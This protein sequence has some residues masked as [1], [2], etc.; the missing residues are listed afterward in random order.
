MLDLSAAF[1]CVDHTIDHTILLRHLQIGAGLTHVVFEWIAS[2]LSKRTQQIAYGGEL[3][4]VQ[5]VL[6]GVP[7]SS[8]LGPLLYVL[9][10]A[11]LFDVVARHQL[12][13]HMYADDSQV[14]VSAPANNA[15]AAV[16]RCEALPTSTTG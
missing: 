9:Y 7:Q 12:R 5:L 11:E 1:D 13:L 2:F 8:V 16:V 4:N 3:S 10:T 14:Y 15:A 6:F